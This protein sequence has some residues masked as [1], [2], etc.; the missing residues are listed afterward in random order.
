[1]LLITICSNTLNCGKSSLPLYRH[2]ETKQF[3]DLHLKPRVIRN[4]YILS[5]AVRHFEALNSLF[6][7]N[8]FMWSELYMTYRQSTSDFCSSFT[9]LP[10]AL[11]IFC[12]NSWSLIN[13]HP[14]HIQLPPSFSHD[15]ST[16]YFVAYCSHHWLVAFFMHGKVIILDSLR[17]ADD[18]LSKVC[19]LNIT[20]LKLLEIYT[21]GL[22]RS[23]A[24]RFYYKRVSV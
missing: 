19:A 24:P 22:G 16:I 3:T 6:H 17:T 8:V 4:K 9:Y 12:C 5:V 23:G 15:V 13:M 21:H 11:A 10:H 1:M 2:L 14:K 20:H 7:R 18:E